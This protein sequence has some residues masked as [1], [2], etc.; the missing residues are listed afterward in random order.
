MIPFLAK[1]KIRTYTLEVLKEYEKRRGK[2]TDFPIDAGDVFSALFDLETIFDTEG[3]LN[4]IDKGIIGGLFPDGH[5]SPWG[6]DKQIVVNAT[7]VGEDKCEK[8]VKGF[9]IKFCSFDPTVYNDNFTIAH[10]GMGH[11][12]LHFLKGITGENLSGPIYCRSNDY[13][14][15]EWQANFAAG[16]LT[17]PFDKV[18]WILDGKEPPEI[19][20]V[21]IYRKNYREYFDA[22][23]GMMERRLT[24]LGYRLINARY[25]WAD[26]L[27]IEKKREKELEKRLK[28]SGEMKRIKEGMNNPFAG[29]SDVGSGFFEFH[30]TF[31]NTFGFPYPENFHKSKKR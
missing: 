30:N 2:K 26:Y 23:Q 4:E 18:K 1:D 14:P 5:P 7:K 10:E 25:K 21:D 8:T 28:A 6:R 24:A 20:D 9:R 11:Y 31:Y 15:L 22:S 29:F 27:S 13:S 19:I 17:Q 12:V 16:E 3:R